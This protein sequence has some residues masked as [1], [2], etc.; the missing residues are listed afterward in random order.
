MLP[1]HEMTEEEAAKVL[2]LSPH[3]LGV[4]LNKGV[5]PSRLHIAPDGK[6]HRLLPREAVEAVRGTAAYKL[7][8]RENAPVKPHPMPP[9][10]PPPP[11]ESPASPPVDP[12]APP[13]PPE[14][15]P[16]APDSPAATPD[17]PPTGEAFQIALLQSLTATQERVATIER[18]I[19]SLMGSIATD[20]A[21]KLAALPTKD[22]LR[23]RTAEAAGSAVEAIRQ[24]TDQVQSLTEALSSA[25]TVQ[26]RNA[27]QQ[28][29]AIQQLQSQ[30]ADLGVSVD[31]QLTALNQRISDILEVLS[32]LPDI[33]ESH[34]E[35][36]GRL[37]EWS[38]E[39]QEKSPLR[40]IQKFGRLIGEKRRRKEEAAD[41]AS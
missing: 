31:Q 24:V 11:A 12:P 4:L 26:A 39:E 5:L 41:D 8:V 33:L 36:L 15:A 1:D 40:Q 19:E 25:T 2:E 17:Q 18:R 10:P 3:E 13:P 38:A 14:T 21:V 35:Q 20:L 30:L 23:T 27:D 28:A 6:R 22:D 9:P 16:V 37:V 29:E 34:G 7:L 32:V